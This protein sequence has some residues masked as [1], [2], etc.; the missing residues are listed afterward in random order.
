MGEYQTQKICGICLIRS[1]W[2]NQQDLEPISRPITFNSK[3]QLIHSVLFCG[4][5]DE[6]FHKPRGSNDGKIQ[7]I[8]KKVLI[9]KIFNFLTEFIF[10]C[11]FSLNPR[12]LDFLFVAQF[13]KYFLQIVI[14]IKT[15]LLSSN[16]AIYCSFIG[17]STNTPNIPTTLLTVCPSLRH[18]D[19]W[20]NQKTSGKLWL[21]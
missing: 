10:K 2:Q 17:T 20:R 11:L 7:R 8:L 14:I 3:N 5:W 18:T 4:L 9:C 6:L 13:L 21:T 1:L 16:W 15:Q 19:S 12:P